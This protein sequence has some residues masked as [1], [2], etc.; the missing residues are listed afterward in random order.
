MVTIFAKIATIKVMSEKNRRVGF[1]ILITFVSLVLLIQALFFTQRAQHTQAMGL[2]TFVWPI[3]GED[4]PD[5]PQSSTYGP[6]LMASQN[7]RYDYHQGID[8]PV[9]IGTQILAVT[10]GTVRI[11]GSHPAYQDGV[12]QINHG[13]NLYSNY[14]HISDSQVITGQEVIPGQPIGLS[15]ISA[16]GFPHLHFEIREGSVFRADTVHPWRF[17]PYEDTIRHTIA[18]TRVFAD[19]RVTVQATTPADEL[20]IQ[21]I[22]VKVLDMENEII[23]G[24]RTLN[25]EQWNRRYGGRPERLDISTL[26]HVVIEPQVYVTASELYVVDVEFQRLSG[27]G[28]VGIIA[29][30]IDVKGNEVCK[31]GVGEF[32]GL[33]GY[34]PTL[35]N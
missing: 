9:P 18:I 32:E 24:G 14:L 29:C 5:L 4:A 30:A 34:L 25:Y 8:I 16:S 31:D 3:S 15:G 12:I 7:F 17:L 22:T 35:Q 33:F 26:G 10:T 11:A 28:L 1:V 27:R 13:N 19:N 2:P 6:R 23:I 20:D 21:A